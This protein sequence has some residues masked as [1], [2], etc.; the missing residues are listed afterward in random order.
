MR[1]GDARSTKEALLVVGGAVGFLC[2]VLAV[3]SM[4]RVVDIDVVSLVQGAIFGFVCAMFGALL[5]GVEKLCAR[6]PS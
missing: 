5:C 3:L 2:S 1:Q 6:R 4:C